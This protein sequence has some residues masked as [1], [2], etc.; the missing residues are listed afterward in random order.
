MPDYYSQLTSEKK[1]Y[2]QILEPIF[3]NWLHE[4]VNT[5]AMLHQQYISTTCG[6]IYT[7]LI[8]E[9]TFYSSLDHSV[10]VALIIWHFTHDK[11]QTIAGL[12]HDIATPV[13]K[14][15]VD[16]LEGDHL[17]QESTEDRTTEIIRNSPEMMELLRRDRIKVEEVDNYHIYPIADND[18][19]RLAADR[20]EYSFANAFFTYH[21]VD[22]PKIAE[23]YHDIEIQI[24]EDNV[25][26][27]GFK[28]KRIAREFTKLVSQL[29]VLYRDPTNIYSMQF[30][31]DILNRLEQDGKITRNELY[32]LKES[33]II[34]IIEGSPYVNIFNQWRKANKIKTSQ[35]KPANVYSVKEKVKVRWVDPL[36]QGQRISNVCKIAKRYIDKNLAYMVDEYIYLDLD[37]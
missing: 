31:A 12:L 14:H 5:P 15:C 26:E 18:K 25:P 20:L 34:E 19:P 23:I 7:N 2:F 6:L 36:F 11:K 37:F 27:L 33:E 16:F 30:L 1:A 3:P 32:C 22:L 17:L 4:Y 9:N 29:S 28:T 24:N 13:F 21:M 10:G 35:K 8:G